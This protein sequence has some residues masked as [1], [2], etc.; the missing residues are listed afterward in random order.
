MTESV[1]ISKAPSSFP[2]Y[3]DFQKLRAAG[4][5][6]VQELGSDLWTDYNLHDP[7][8]TILEVLCYALTD[9]GFRTN[10]DIEDLLTRSPD[11]KAQDQARITKDGKLYDDNF[12]TAE[13]ILTCNPVTLLDL[14]KLL[15]D[16]SGVR[17]AWLQRATEAELALYI[18]KKKNRLQYTLPAAVDK[19]KKEEVDEARVSLKGLYTVCLETDPDPQLDACGRPYIPTGDILEQ[20]CAVLHRHR[21]LCEDFLDVVVLADEEIGIC[22]DIELT[23]EADPEDVLLGIYTAVQE[24]LSPTF[25]FYSLQEMLKKGKSV[26]EIFEGRPLSPESHGFIDVEVLEQAELREILHASDLYQEIMDVE[27]VLAIRK[28]VFSN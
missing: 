24:F 5:E 22:A 26:E 21:N 2:D 15:I 6:H 3:L 14:R 16:I 4:L 23:A 25:Q 1:T 12:Y 18:D 10:F 27:G 9:L 20:V 7:G 11:A 28:F 19:T 8:I 17:N 13:Q